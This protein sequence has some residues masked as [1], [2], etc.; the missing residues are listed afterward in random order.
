MTSFYLLYPN[1]LDKDNR[2]KARTPLKLPRPSW[3]LTAQGPYAITGGKVTG[4]A[5]NGVHLVTDVTK[6]QVTGLAITGAPGRR[7]CM[8]C[9]ITCSPPFSPSS[10]MV[11][12]PNSPPVL[13]RRIAALPSGTV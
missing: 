9:T 10:T 1:G 3:Q 4:A 8:P 7:V 2:I 11:S 5:A 6:L 12:A 13:M